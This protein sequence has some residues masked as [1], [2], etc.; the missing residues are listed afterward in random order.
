MARLG[1]RVSRYRCL[2]PLLFSM[3]A[4]LFFLPVYDAGLAYCDA[5]PIERRMDCV[6]NVTL[7]VSWI[8]LIPFAFGIF[9]FAYRIYKDWCQVDYFVERNSQR[10]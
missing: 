4:L 1:N 2:A 10:Q 3:A 5:Q 8:F 7:S 6:S 9:A